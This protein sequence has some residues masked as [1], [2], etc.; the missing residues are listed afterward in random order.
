MQFLRQRNSIAST[1]N[2]HLPFNDTVFA[3]LYYRILNELQH[4]LD[5]SNCLLFLHVRRNSKN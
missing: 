1:E 2:E 3:C 4:S 5:K